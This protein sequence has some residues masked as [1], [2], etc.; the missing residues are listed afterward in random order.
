MTWSLQA[1]LTLSHMAVALLSVLLGSAVANGLLESRFRAYVSE[2][3][4]KRNQQVA[5]LVGSQL[6]EDGTWDLGGVE[7]V[8]VGALEQGVIVKVTDATGSTVWDATQHNSGMCEQMLSHMAENMASRY[9]N[10]RGAYTESRYPLGSSGSGSG[11]VTIGFYGPFFLNDADLLF[12]NTL[13]R[14]LLLVTV[15]AMGLAVAAGSFMARGLARPLARAVEA[16]ERIAGGDLGVRIPSGSRVRELAG[17]TGAVNELAQA[18]GS[19]ESLRRRLT[20]DMAHELRTPLA[21]LQSHME[22]LIDGVWEPDRERIC[23]LYEEVMRLSRLV[24][25]LESL[26]TLEREVLDLAKRRTDLAGL[27]RGIVANHEPQFRAENVAVS[28]AADGTGTFAEV[29]QD[30]MSQAV[31]NV[32][33]NALKFTPAGGHVSVKVHRAP[34]GGAAVEVADTGIG[35]GPE[36]L[37]RIFERFYRVDASRSRGTGGSGIG[38]SIAK[39]IA[40]AHG[41]TID[42]QSQPGKGSRFTLIVPLA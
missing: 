35:I 40:E 42:A 20:A 31:I 21:T 32:L 8:G 28:F 24:A 12:I 39:A 11:S 29:D 14:L 30:R 1:R 27:V 6:R 7:T 10:W 38:L 33:S 22:A 5:D 19:Q 25:D 26:A 3:Q 41:G 15:A 18:L 23:G 4:Q 16:T 36:D 2:T 17:L 37:P 9:P 34:N 13:N